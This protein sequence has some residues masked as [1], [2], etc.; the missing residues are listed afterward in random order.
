MKLNQAKVEVITDADAAVFEAA[1]NTFLEAQK[2]E[3]LV[4]MQF[5]DSGSAY[6]A[7]IVYTK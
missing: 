5:T 1:V 3:T 7:Y 2:E 4:S 6:T